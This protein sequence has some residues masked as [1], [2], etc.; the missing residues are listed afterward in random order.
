[1]RIRPKAH[2][3]EENIKLCLFFPSHFVDFELK[4]SSTINWLGG[5]AKIHG[6]VSFQQL[7]VVKKGV[8]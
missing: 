4:K 6:D 7:L 5:W 1:M 2:D 8:R 3:D